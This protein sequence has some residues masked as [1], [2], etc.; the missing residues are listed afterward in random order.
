MLN[1]APHHRQY[2]Q[3]SGGSLF[4][5][6]RISTRYKE[7]LAR[8]CGHPGVI[9]RQLSKSYAEEA[10]Y[11]RL[12]ENNRFSF[13][14]ILRCEGQQTLSNSQGRHVLAISDTTE[15]NLE[16][17]ADHYTDKELCGYL[18]NNRS[19]GV[20]AQ[21]SIALDA[22]HLW[23]LGLSDLILWG[24][25]KAKEKKRTTQ[26]D[27]LPREE[28]ESHKW[29]LGVS[30]CREVLAKASQITYVFDREADILELFQEIDQQ[31]AD[32][33]IRIKHD[34]KLEQREERISEALA[35]SDQRFSHQV[36]IR[37]EKARKSARGHRIKARKK[38]K[39]EMMLSFTPIQLK[40][41]KRTYY[42][43]DV[44]E[45]PH[46][47]PEGE[48]P[49]QWRLLTTH[50]IDSLTDALKVVGFYKARW[51]IEELFR[52]IK[53]QGFQIETVQ[54]RTVAS[55]RKMICMTMT[56][57][58]NILQLDLAKSH[59][60]QMPIEL[61]FNQQQIMLLKLLSNKL[62]GNTEKQK[63]PYSDQDL[64]FAHWVMARLGG[65]KGYL[66]KRPPGPIT[67]LRGNRKF[68]QFLEA[69]EL[70]NQKDVWEP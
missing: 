37:G 66:S 34:R 5:D 36:M 70:F 52:I 17:R 55:I 67:L 58:L 40:A 44:V 7:L 42:V 59:Q 60:I 9:L 68:S 62:E 19:R 50:P 18:S 25:P 64:L 69:F 46:S 30:G 32:F 12:L 43:V 1:F 61:A 14:D 65:W 49:I 15:I 26:R 10:A 24:R 8:M 35:Q 51:M 2:G 31:G 11:Y 21:A 39:A 41:C 27:S 38:R 20:I 16:S 23:V 28:K 4:K 6:K 3:L 33:V 47:V 29:F 13:E 57:G 63:N 54:L 53:S 22:E 56:A 48:K 45:K